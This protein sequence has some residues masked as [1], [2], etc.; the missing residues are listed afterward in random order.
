[1]LPNT[2]TRILEYLRKQQTASVHDLSRA[3]GM[4]GANIRHHL[5]FL[6]STGLV[7]PVSER[8]EGRG[9]PV[10]FYGLSRRVIGDGLQD[11]AKALLD[12]FVKSSTADMQEAGM[13]SLALSLGSKA[14]SPSEPLLTHRLAQTI[15]LLNKLHYQA[16]WEAGADGPHII[17]GLCPY[18][19][20]IGAYPELCRM[21]AF[22]L[23]QQAG[24]PVE[25]A[26]KLQPST[27]GYPYCLFKLTVKK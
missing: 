15:D 7:E 11:L 12:V 14:A 13:Q 4:T 8:R 23:E 24:R 5:S 21:D 17:L 19:A 9:R 26:A 22:L 6:E 25:Q 1:M 20:I 10:R 18:S 27:G 2:R 16:H 3:L